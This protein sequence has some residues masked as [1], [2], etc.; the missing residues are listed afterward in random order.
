MDIFAKFSHQHFV[1]LW[2]SWRKKEAQAY[3]E[4]FKKKEEQVAKVEDQGEAT[5]ED[6]QAEY[7]RLYEKEP[8]TAY[9]NNADWLKK[10]INE[11]K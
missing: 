8:A 1:M 7:I 6:L 2:E 5:L 11:S 3:R 9:K 10:K 4:S